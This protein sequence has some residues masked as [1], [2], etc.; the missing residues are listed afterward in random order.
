LA[1]GDSEAERKGLMT[2]ATRFECELEDSPD[3]SGNKVM[4]IR[5]HGRLV[6]DTA[7]ELKDL[8]KPLIGKGGRIVIDLTDVSHLDSSGLGTLVGLKVSAMNA[9]L[10][11]LEL[12]NVS[13]HISELLRISKL[14]QLFAS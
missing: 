10:C 6:S 13:K 14:T 8:V 1:E 11:I 9:G 2:T 12:S 3:Q 4:T 7:Q 5:C